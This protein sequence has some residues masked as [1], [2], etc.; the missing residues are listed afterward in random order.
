[1]SPPVAPSALPPQEGYASG[2]AKPVARRPRDVL[3]IVDE[4]GA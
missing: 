1:M 4:L 3:R 2:P